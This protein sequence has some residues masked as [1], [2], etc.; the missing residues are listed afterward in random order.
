[1]VDKAI[2]K[3]EKAVQNLDQ[4]RASAQT[5][6]NFSE[7]ILDRANLDQKTLDKQLAILR[8]S[9]GDL[10]QSFGSGA[11]ETTPDS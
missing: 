1:M 7:K 2:L 4:I 8:E 11:A 9:I 3:I 10:K 6:K 5:I